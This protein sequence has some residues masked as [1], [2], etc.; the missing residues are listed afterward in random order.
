MNTLIQ[1]EALSLFG[2]DIYYSH[3]NTKLGFSANYLFEI[4]KEIVTKIFS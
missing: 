3:N 2:D 4:Y 1:N